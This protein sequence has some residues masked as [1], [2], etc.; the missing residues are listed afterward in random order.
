MRICAVVK[1]PPIQ[2]GV[3]ARSYWIARSLAMQGHEVHVVT[4][5]GEVEPEYRLWLTAEDRRRLT[6]SFSNGGRVTV[7]S[8]G[9]DGRR[10]RHVPAGN[11]FVSKLSA[12]ACE[13]IRRYGCEVVF[14]YYYEPYGIAAHLASM[15][16]GIPHV[17]QHAGSDRG[18]LMNH[19]ELSMAYREMLRHASVVVTGNPS[20]AGLGIEPDRLARV[21]GSFL[22]KGLFTPDGPVME[23]D[24]VLALAAE[25]PFVRNRRPW[26]A[27]PPVIGVLGKA[28]EAKGLYEL[29]SALGQLSSAGRDFNLLAMVAGTERE[30]FLASVDHHGL[31][32]RTWT[33]PLVAHWRVPEFLRASTAVCFLENRFPIAAHQPGVPREILATGTC[34]VLSGEIAAKQSFRAR[35]RHGE[36]A[37]VVRDPADTGELAGALHQVLS[38]PDLARRI[39]AAGVD[40][41]RAGDEAVLACAYEEVFQRAIRPVVKAPAT[42]AFTARRMP[43]TERL[44]S[45]ELDAA[46]NG[47][48]DP[49]ET[50]RVVE[51]L[52]RNQSR[53]PTPDRRVAVLAFEAELLWLGIDKESRVGMPMFPDV[54]GDGLFPVMS[55]WVRVSRH[56]A[57]ITEAVRVLAAGGPAMPVLTETTVPYVFQK[58]GDLSSRVFRIGEAT[59]ELLRLCDGSLGIES[60]LAAGV[61]EVG[62]V[63]E[64]LQGLAREQ[65]IA[66]RRAFAS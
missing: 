36:N 52:L 14:S 6:A 35:I 17:V 11:P 39:G 49:E 40:L 46:L 51:L 25:H 61:G 59:A 13:T 3:S 28:G 43:A 45:A 18:R 58:R 23:V 19:P 8:T 50:H 60:I 9:A 22:P 34:A 63:R 26:R 12:L 24:S 42:R 54:I 57:N 21:P 30:R 27:G 2:G 53:Q 65:V 5:A 16:T 37:V 44:F 55:N 29:L 64:A 4:N 38:E 32:P 66:F 10:L 7:V 20:V 62:R 56:P 47:A 33:L 31:G 48:V 41:V 1:Y 15:W